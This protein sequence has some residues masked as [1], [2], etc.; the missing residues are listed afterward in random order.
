MLGS[1]ETFN[2]VLDPWIHL[3]ALKDLGMDGPQVLQEVGAIQRES[4]GM[5][6]ENP[7]AQPILH[8]AV[9]TRVLKQ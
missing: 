4:Q 5:P 7:V 2:I 1:Q 9:G 3:Q 6:I 8:L